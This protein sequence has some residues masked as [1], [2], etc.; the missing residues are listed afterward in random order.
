M[1]VRSSAFVI[2]WV[3]PATTVFTISTISALYAVWYYRQQRVVFGR[4]D[5]LTATLVHV[6]EQ[7]PRAG[8]EH[9]RQVHASAYRLVAIEPNFP[10][11]IEQILVI[12]HDEG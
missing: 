8:A 6:G 7:E 12:L 10:G 3:T 4:R 1:S 2:G 5:L 11:R 9:P